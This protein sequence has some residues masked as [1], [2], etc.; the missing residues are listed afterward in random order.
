MLNVIVP[1][2]VLG[3]T[4][5]VNVTGWV[6]ADGFGDEESAVLV[7]SGVTFWKRMGELLPALFVSPE[8]IA[9]IC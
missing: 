6:N 1:V 9:V 8:Y 4:A 2:A 7:L 3:V 5:A